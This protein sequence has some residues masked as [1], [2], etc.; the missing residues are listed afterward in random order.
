MEWEGDY[1]ITWRHANVDEL[2][3]FVSS[4]HNLKITQLSHTATQATILI[5]YVQT[6]LGAPQACEGQVRLVPGP[7]SG[8][9]EIHH[10]G[11]WGEY[12]MFDLDVL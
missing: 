5:D 4:T 3:P 6:P 2:A 8:R 1:A 10:S 9:L 11:V 7:F 12:I